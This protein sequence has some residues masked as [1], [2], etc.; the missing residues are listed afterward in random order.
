MQN[1]GM[2]IHAGVI[3]RKNKWYQIVIYEKSKILGNIEIHIIDDKLGMGFV[4]T[5]NGRILLTKMWDREEEFTLHGSFYINGVD[6]RLILDFKKDE[7]W[8]QL[9]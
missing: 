8:V 6:Y 1:K 2:F 5:F 7:I 9:M 4:A 3:S